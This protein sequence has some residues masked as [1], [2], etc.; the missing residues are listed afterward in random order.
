[1]SMLLAVD[2]TCHID[3]VD[4]A[5]HSRR[6]D[7]LVVAVGKAGLV[8]SDMVKPGCIVIDGT[9]V[10]SLAARTAAHTHWH[11]HGARGCVRVVKWASTLCPTTRKSRASGCAVT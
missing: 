6:A 7:V 1:M 9:C 8:R 3:T 5:S 10:R 11:A 4:V 2:R